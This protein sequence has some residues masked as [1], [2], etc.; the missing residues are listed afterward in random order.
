MSGVSPLRGAERRTSSSVRQ[1]VEG[2]DKCF[3]GGELAIASHSLRR[4]WARRAE[5]DRATTQSA[6]THLLQR[7]KDGFRAI[8]HTDGR[9]LRVVSRR[10]TD[11]AGRLPELEPLAS[12]LAAGTTL[13]GEL[14]VLGTD[15]RV[16]FEGMRIEAA[17]FSS[18]VGQ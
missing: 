1:H 12:V 9:R 8:V 6:T 5:V 15:G 2:G 13:D 18:I 10:G 11:L 3:V 16:D 4:A 17:S 7:K 14:V